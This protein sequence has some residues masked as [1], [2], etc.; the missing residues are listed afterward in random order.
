MALMGV[1]QEVFAD[2]LARPK[3]KEYKNDTKASLR[4]NNGDPRIKTYRELLQAGKYKE[5]G[6]IHNEIS[7]DMWR[8]FLGSARA[9]DLSAASQY[10]ARAEGR[11]AARYRPSRLDPLYDGEKLVFEPGKKAELLGKHFETK[12]SQTRG[13]KQVRVPVEEIKQQPLKGTPRGKMGMDKKIED[14]R[15]RQHGTF[16]ATRPRGRTYFR[17]S[18]TRNVWSCKRL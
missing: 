4:S 13:K 3:R 2:R 8:S 18:S 11:L 7:R 12:M 14:W 17:R 15:G 10:L 5:C 9:N 16:R 1:Q 6:E